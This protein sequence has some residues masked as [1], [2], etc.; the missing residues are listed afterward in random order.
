MYLLITFF[1]YFCSAFFRSIV[2]GDRA[3]GYRTAVEHRLNLNIVKRNQ[4]MNE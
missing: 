3:M 1:D 2:A 4:I